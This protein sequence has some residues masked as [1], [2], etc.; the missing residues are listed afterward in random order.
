MHGLFE[1][2]DGLPNTLAQLRE[3]ACAE[4]DQHDEQN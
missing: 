3:F 2:F 4:N 1:A